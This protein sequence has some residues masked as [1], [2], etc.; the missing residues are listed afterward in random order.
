MN[1]FLPLNGSIVNSKG[2]VD[3]YPIILR[4]LLEHILL[5]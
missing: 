1:T 3:V 5:N 4:L 2:L